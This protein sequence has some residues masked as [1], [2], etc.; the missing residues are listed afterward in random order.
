MDEMLATAAAHWAPRLTANGVLPSDFNRV[1]S[2][3][4]TWKEWCPAWIGVGRIHEDLGSR[5][6][7]EGRSRSAGQHFVRAAVSY[8]FGKFVYFEDMEQAGVA[9][10]SAARCLA[11]ALPHLDTP[12]RRIEF[13]FEGGTMV[14]VLLTPW[15]SGP[16]PLL[17]MIPGLDSTKEELMAQAGDFL[18]RGV[19][20]LLLDG[21]GQGEAEANLPI[22]A[23]YEIAMAAV[24]SRLAE[25]PDVDQER[26]AVWGVSLGGY[27]A[28]RSASALPQLRACVSV[29]GAYCMR[30]VI[31]AGPPMTREA[32][33]RRSF[34]ADMEAAI[35]KADTL[36][37]EGRA[38]KIS[39]PLLVIGGKRDRLIPWTDQARLAEETGG[40]L[41]LLDEGGHACGNMTDHHRPY[42]G[43]WIA[44]RLQAG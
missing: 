3:I 40:E 32:F 7:A 19:A 39:C 23:D 22:R 11:A 18:T 27:Y 34:S 38:E 13:P 14:G 33:R 37:L 4:S 17:V 9:A 26:I 24:L 1:M 31:E 12:A 15:T 30:P 6:E 2:T 42:T 41:L 20:T 36:T 5:A 10:S 43:D 35:E 25:E 28:P 21:P 29:S 16:H 8:H 44:A